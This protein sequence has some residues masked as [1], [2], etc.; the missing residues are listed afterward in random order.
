[1]IPFLKTSLDTVGTYRYPLI[2]QQ[3]KTVCSVGLYEDAQDFA[4]HVLQS[5]T[6]V[7]PD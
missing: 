6:S 5:W 2:V 4:H 7:S 1:M 3:K